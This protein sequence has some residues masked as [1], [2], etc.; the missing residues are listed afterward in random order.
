MSIIDRLKT[1]N[2]Q[3]LED[4]KNRFKVFAKKDNQ[5]RNLKWALFFSLAGYPLLILAMKWAGVL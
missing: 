3:L 4:E 5:I 1:Q 2:T